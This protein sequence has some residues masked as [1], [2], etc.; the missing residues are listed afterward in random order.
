MSDLKTIIESHATEF[1]Q[2]IIASL[3][4]LSIDDL[5]RLSQ[6]GGAPARATPAKVPV[7]VKSNG[8]PA[9]RTKKT[10]S[11][12]LAR[13]SLADIDATLDQIVALLKKK[14]GLRAEQIGAELGL[15]KKEVPRPILEGLKRGSLSKAGER[16]GTTYYAEKKK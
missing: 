11:G 3:K 12:R 6:G 1:A 8:A 5:V 15:D 16:R 4:D 10:S 7:A 9:L 13:R 2:A 14:P